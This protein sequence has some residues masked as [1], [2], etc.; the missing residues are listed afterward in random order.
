MIFIGFPVS[1]STI[2]G[3]FSTQNAPFWDDT[4]TNPGLKIFGYKVMTFQSMKSGEKNSKWELKLSN[5]H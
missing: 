5:L 1:K 3:N 2:I 4:I